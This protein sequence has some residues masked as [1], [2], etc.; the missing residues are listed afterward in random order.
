[1]TD[2][3]MAQIVMIISQVYTPFKLIKLDTLSTA[4]AMSK[5]K[6]KHSKERMGGYGIRE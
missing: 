1:M 2:K 4:F 5:N 3:P 6:K